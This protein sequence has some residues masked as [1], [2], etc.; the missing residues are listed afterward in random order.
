MSRQIDLTKKLSDEDRA[1]LVARD[2]WRDIALADGHEDVNRAKREATENNDI[3]QGRRP[4]TLVGEQ[5]LVQQAN[6]NPPTS[7]EE[8]MDYDSWSF[9]DLKQELDVRKE[10]ALAEGMSPDEANKLFSKGGGQKDLVARLVADDERVG[11][12]NQQ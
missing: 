9:D 7:T 6:E 1:Y 10:E 12:Q 8:D 5:A 3:L 11:Q 4:P 2:R